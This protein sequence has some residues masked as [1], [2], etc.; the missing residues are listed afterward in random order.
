M[1]RIFLRY[2]NDY[3]K[4]PKD[5]INFGVFIPLVFAGMTFF[6]SYQ[7]TLVEAQRIL[8]NRFKKIMDMSEEGI[9]IIKEKSTIEYLNDKFIE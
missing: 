3:L 9:V 1:Y 7:Q 6:G 8:L 4:E 2:D 5:Y